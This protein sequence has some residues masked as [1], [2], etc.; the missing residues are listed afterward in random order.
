MNYESR[1]SVLEGPI[2]RFDPVIR[3]KAIIIH[4]LLGALLITIPINVVVRTWKIGARA[5][6]MPK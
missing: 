6:M 3:K 1:P 2:R 5:T 4:I